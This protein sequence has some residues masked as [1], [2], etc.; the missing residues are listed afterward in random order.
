MCT[1]FESPSEP[2]EVSFTFFITQHGVVRKEIS[3]RAI[4]KFCDA[5]SNLIDG[6]VI[7]FMLASDFLNILGIIFF[8][9]RNLL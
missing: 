6:V 4:D 2:P 9:H 7:V 3:G 5:N 8:V 1:L